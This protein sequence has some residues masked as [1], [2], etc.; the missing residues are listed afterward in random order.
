LGGAGQGPKG[1]KEKRSYQRRTEREDE[2]GEKE[3]E[4]EETS[5]VDLQDSTSGAGPGTAWEV[6]RRSAEG[7]ITQL[8]AEKRGGTR[9]VF[10]S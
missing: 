1:G 3:G 2:G 4:H 5:I 9:G 6:G 8:I 7:W 10:L